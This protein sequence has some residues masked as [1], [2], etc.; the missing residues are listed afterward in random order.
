M[1]RTWVLP[2]KAIWLCSSSVTDRMGAV[3]PINETIAM[4]A[5][6][7]PKMILGT[8]SRLCPAINFTSRPTNAAS[9]RVMSLLADRLTWAVALARP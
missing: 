5:R 8:R 6:A 2:C 9:V 1:A 7:L 3:M 4:S